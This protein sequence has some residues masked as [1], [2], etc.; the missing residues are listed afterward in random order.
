MNY[1]QGYTWRWAPILMNINER[2]AHCECSSNSEMILSIEPYHAISTYGPNMV[3]TCQNPPIVWYG[4][5]LGSS[6]GYIHIWTN[7]IWFTIL[8]VTL[9]KP[10]IILSSTDSIMKTLASTNLALLTIG[11]PLL[12]YRT[13]IAVTGHLD[14]VPCRK[15]MKPWKSIGWTSLEFEFPYQILFF[16][17]ISILWLFREQAITRRDK[18]KLKGFQNKKPETTARMLC[19]DFN[20]WFSVRRRSMFLGKA[21]ILVCA[22]A[23]H[24]TFSSNLI[25]VET[26]RSC[27]IMMSWYRAKLQ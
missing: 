20:Q 25:Q 8:I 21:T 24:H 22:G 4:S 23:C 16:V 2:T 9:V 15:S 13:A 3:K 19:D 14:H 11:Q 18:E 1:F 5:W 7:Y 26:P 17:Y 6:P 12:Q 10:S 27:K